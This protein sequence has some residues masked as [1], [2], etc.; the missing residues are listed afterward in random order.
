[1]R[2]APRTVT[3]T[4]A[5]QGGRPL[6]CLLPGALHPGRAARASIQ[7]GLTHEPAPAFDAMSSK[8]PPSPAV[9]RSTK[10]NETPPHGAPLPEDIRTWVARTRHRESP[11]IVERA[12]IC[13]VHART[14]HACR[15]VTP[16]RGRREMVPST[17]LR[18]AAQA[19]DWRHYRGAYGQRHARGGAPWSYVRHHLSGPCTNSPP[20]LGSSLPAMFVAEMSSR[21]S[22]VSSP[23][24]TLAQ[25]CADLASPRVR[26]P[27]TARYEL[28]ETTPLRTPS[29][30]QY[31]RRYQSAFSHRPPQPAV[32]H[33]DILNEDPGTLYRLILPGVRPGSPLRQLLKMQRNPTARIST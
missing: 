9:V 6:V 26:G 33:P 2:R 20:D 31:W 21:D 27:Y 32:R 5:H 15:V 23:M 11:E 18:T 1:M 24:R 4:P 12:N 19:T 17:A 7:I 30:A 10:S 8:P 22:W 25:M 3:A 16:Y 29:H 28:F 13:A 14:L